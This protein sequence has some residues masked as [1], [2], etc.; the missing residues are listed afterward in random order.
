M[1]NMVRIEVAGDGG[2]W[3]QITRIPSEPAYNVRNQLRMAIKSR[4]AQMVN[5]N[6]RL[7]KVG[8]RARAVD[9][10]TGALVDMEFE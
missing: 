2:N 1:T 3:I 4:T 7:G 6:S 5:N 9:E 8:A 10:R